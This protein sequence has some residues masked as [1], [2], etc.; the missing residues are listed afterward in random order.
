LTSQEI[1]A[2]TD[3]CIVADVSAD[4]FPAL[5]SDATLAPPAALATDQGLQLEQL[6]LLFGPPPVAVYGSVHRKDTLASHTFLVGWL[7]LT[8]CCQLETNLKL[9]VQG[10]RHMQSHRHLQTWDRSQLQ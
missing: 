10:V 2:Y 9:Q 6:Q 4:M 1:S 7:F 3:V 8:D 5:A